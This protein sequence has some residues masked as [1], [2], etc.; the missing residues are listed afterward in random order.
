MEAFVFMK[1]SKK[2]ALVPGMSGSANIL[3]KEGV[4]KESH[5]F[6]KI[7]DFLSLQ[8]IFKK[9]PPELSKEGFYFES[10]GGHFEIDEGIMRTEN[11]IL[12]S[13]VLNT[14]ASG[15]VDLTKR[16]VSLNLGVQPLETVDTLV[17][18]VPILG[19]ILTGK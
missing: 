9:R 14:V 1:G 5:T 15:E 12:K 19:H 2:E 18:K 7:L 16:T 8:N 17:S 13:P 10:M 3:V 11:G 6:L 4:L